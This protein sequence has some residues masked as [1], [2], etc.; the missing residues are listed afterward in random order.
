MSRLFCDPV[1]NI[2]LLI[3]LVECYVSVTTCDKEKKKRN[4]NHKSL[5]ISA[6]GC[7]S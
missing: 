2:F 3:A 7:V 4:A 5:L 6:L 1:R